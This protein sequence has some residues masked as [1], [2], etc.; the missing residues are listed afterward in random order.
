MTLDRWIASGDLRAYQKS[1]KLVRLRRADLDAF[2]LEEP[3]ASA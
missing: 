1:R 3:N 2:M